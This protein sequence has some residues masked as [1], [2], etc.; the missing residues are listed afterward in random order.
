MEKSEGEAKEKYFYMALNWE[1]QVDKFVRK[2]DLS[3]ANLKNLLLKN[4]STRQLENICKFMYI[5]YIPGNRLINLMYWAVT[6]MPVVIVNKMIRMF[7]WVSF[8]YL[9]NRCI[10]KVLGQGNRF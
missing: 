8:F 10:R 1:A 2:G 6:S 4:L 7:A 3:D 9:K 5:E